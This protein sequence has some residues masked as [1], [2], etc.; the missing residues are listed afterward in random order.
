MYEEYPPRLFFVSR[1]SRPIY[2]DSQPVSNTTL[3]ATIYIPES[4]SSNPPAFP[5]LKMMFHQIII[6]IDIALLLSYYLS[7]KLYNYYIRR[8]C[9]RGHVF[10]DLE[11]SKPPWS[12][13]AARSDKPQGTDASTENAQAS[14]EHQRMIE[15]QYSLSYFRPGLG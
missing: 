13:M 6:L 9:P 4:A 14:G 1:P 7:L 5:Q 10:T 3:Q 2:P 12:P 11:S 8:Y 15:A